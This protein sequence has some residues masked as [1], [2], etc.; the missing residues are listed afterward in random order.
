MFASD[1]EV[2]ET[3]DQVLMK[4]QVQEEMFT[5]DMEVDE[6]GDVSSNDVTNTTKRQLDGTVVVS[7]ERSSS[8][9]CHKQCATCGMQGR[10]RKC[11]NC[12]KAGVKTYY[13]SVICQSRH[14]ST[15]KC[16]T[17][18]AAASVQG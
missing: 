8:L 5:N 3:G 11:E 13:C 9:E 2:D 17:A 1:M 10:L 15:H 14:W 6:T 7:V 18:G 12:L 16:V 4:P